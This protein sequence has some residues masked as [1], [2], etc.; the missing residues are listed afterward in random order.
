M[1]AELRGDFWLALS[2]Q[3]DDAKVAMAVLDDLHRHDAEAV[4]RFAHLAIALAVVWDHPD[5]ID[6][7][8]CTGIFAIDDAQFS[9]SMLRA[10]T[11]R[12]ACA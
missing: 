3:F 7:S 9:N 8:R 10:R 1:N 6:T 2:P 4:K 11:C 5:A 12:S